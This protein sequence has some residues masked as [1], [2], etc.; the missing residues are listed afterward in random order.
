MALL[1]RH[2]ESRWKVPRGGIAF[3]YVS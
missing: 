1:Y 3:A 2:F